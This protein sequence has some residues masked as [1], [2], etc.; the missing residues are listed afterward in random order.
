MKRELKNILENKKII[1]ISLL[2]GFLIGVIIG[3]GAGWAHAINLV[4]DKTLTIGNF[5]EDLKIKIM[6]RCVSN[7]NGCVG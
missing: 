2:I 1:L 4:I 3:Y 5:S 7:F 6:E